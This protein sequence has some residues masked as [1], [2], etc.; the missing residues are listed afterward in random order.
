MADCYSAIQPSDALIKKYLAEIE[1]L[2][3]DDRI[4]NDDYYLLR[5]HRV[6]LNLLETKSMGDPDAIDATSTEEILDSIIQSISGKEAK[7]RTDEIQTHP[8]TKNK[9]TQRE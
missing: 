2:K 8:K 9:L 1:K 4:S 6:S 5:T 3:A 7:R